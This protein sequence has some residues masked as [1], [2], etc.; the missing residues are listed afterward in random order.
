MTPTQVIATEGTYSATGLTPDEPDRYTQIRAADAVLT[1]Q[2][3]PSPLGIYS[4]NGTFCLGPRSLRRSRAECQ[5][6]EV[7]VVATGPFD[8]PA[9]TGTLLS[10]PI[11]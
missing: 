10:C 7:E 4:P 2:S 6:D 9:G 1:T 8:N 11:I 3:P 5:A